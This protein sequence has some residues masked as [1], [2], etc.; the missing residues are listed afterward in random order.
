MTGRH[1]RVL[2]V[3]GLLCGAHAAALA[4]PGA[5]SMPPASVVPDTVSAELGGP[6]HWP[7]P[8]AVSLWPAE[9]RFGEVA[10]LLLDFPG[11]VRGFRADSLATAA[12]WLEV[13]SPAADRPWWRR[14]GGGD[15]P[16]ARIAAEA[17]A[18]AAGTWR[19]AVPVR[20]YTTGPAQIV[21]RD[22]PGTGVFPVR[23]RLGATDESAAVR[24]PRGLGW[25]AGRVAFVVL[26]LVATAVLALWLRRRLRRGATAVDRPLPVP[27]WL[28]AAI[29]LWRL[30]QEDLP[31]RGEGRAFLDRLAAILRAYVAARYHLPACESTATELLAAIEGSG[32]PETPLRDFVALIAA[33]DADRF[34][35]GRIEPARCRADLG[36]AVAL[37]AAVRIEPR[38]TPV[39]A[40]L[41]VEAE[42]AWQGLCR[43]H[44]GDAP[45][46]VA[47]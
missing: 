5:A 46:E 45:R 33:A 29:A 25:Y 21:W 14:W 20:V 36:R 31:A 37:I 24:D 3:C 44:L 27:G 23:G 32:W 47:A 39:P 22:G 1:V 2:L 9:P 43:R 19:A 16:A 41:K 4:Q 34:A 17:T 12:D 8:V 13:V 30:D 40:A 26:A 11:E 7:A 38:Y 18:P 42:A 6:R 10:A 35:P 28:S 15:D